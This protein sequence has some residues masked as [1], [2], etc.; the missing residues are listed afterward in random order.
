MNLAGRNALVTGGASGIGA[1]VAESL[2]N[3]GANVTVVDVNKDARTE[4]CK[5]LGVRAEV[6]DVSSSQAWND[7]I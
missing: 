5:R 1:A 2:E 4:T 3:A 7:F 6:L